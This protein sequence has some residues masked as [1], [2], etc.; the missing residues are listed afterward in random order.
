MGAATGDKLCTVTLAAEDPVQHLKKLIVETPLNLL[1][2]DQ[3]LLLPNGLR[4]GESV[5]FARCFPQPVALH[6]SLSL[7]LGRHAAA[8][9]LKTVFGDAVR[10]SCSALI[11]S[12]YI[13][14]RVSAS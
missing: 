8:V 13:T 9:E 10:S 12:K 5:G 7:S 2:S 11:A 3:I 14:V 6:L 1:E 4:L